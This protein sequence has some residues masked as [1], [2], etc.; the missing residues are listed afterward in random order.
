[1][2]KAVVLAMLKKQKRLY[3]YLVVLSTLL[4]LPVIGQALSF[5]FLLPTAAQLAL[6]IGI[7]VLACR[8]KQFK[9]GAIL[10][11]I[12]TGVLIL[13]VVLQLILLII[14]PSAFDI[15]S[16]GT[17]IYAYIVLVLTTCSWIL[18][19]VATVF[20][21]IGREKVGRTILEMEAGG[22]FDNVLF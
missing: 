16:T 22:I 2:E 11:I 19:I 17:E 14:L 8:T 4:A 6:A 20:N 13:V 5:L 3:S 7:L 15:L 9:V 1:M 21:Y 12:S 18:Q 10:T